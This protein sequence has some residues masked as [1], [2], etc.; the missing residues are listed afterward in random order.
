MG[1]VF[2]MIN[3]DLKLTEEEMKIYQDFLKTG[4][5]PENKRQLGKRGFGYSDF[6]LDLRENGDVFL[7]E[8]IHEDDIRILS[9][10]DK[11]SN[12]NVFYGYTTTRGRYS[13]NTIKANIVLDGKNYKKTWIDKIKENWKPIAT[14]GIVAAVAATGAPYVGLVSAPFVYQGLKIAKDYYEMLSMKDERADYVDRNKGRIPEEYRDPYVI[15]HDTINE[16]P[17]DKIKEK[18]KI[19]LHEFSKLKI[20][21]HED[22]YYLREDG[23]LLTLTKEEMETYKKFLQSD[24]PF[25]ARLGTGLTKL[26]LCENG[27][28]CIT[29]PADMDYG[30]RIVAIHDKL[31]N[32]D[33]FYGEHRDLYTGETVHVPYEIVMENEDSKFV[34]EY[35]YLGRADKEI[36]EI[37]YINEE[38]EVRYREQARFDKEADKME[39]KLL[40]NME[41]KGDKVLFHF[42][43]EIEFTVHGSKMTLNANSHLIYECSVSEKNMIATQL[44]RTI[45]NTMTDNYASFSIGNDLTNS[46][47]NLVKQCKLSNEPLLPSEKFNEPVKTVVNL[48]L[49]FTKEKIENELVM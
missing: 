24:K 10:H 19:D 20:F 49:K 35:S 22:S 40:Q 27:T 21:S 42:R 46:A 47:D 34:K 5:A 23:I 44:A 18:S 48:K 26:N 30:R 36:Y 45:V 25:S 3:I 15:I 43:P 39:E 38:R 41:I 29:E 12:P 16:K 1:E 13:Q 31:S 37:K 4:K 6:Y 32:P 14:T 33:L 7:C 9:M 17:K 2:V 28:V 8:R 11:G